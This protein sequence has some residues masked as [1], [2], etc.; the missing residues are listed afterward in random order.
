MV[1]IREL[2]KA[3]RKALFEWRQDQLLYTD[4]KAPL[5]VAYKAHCTWF[6][7]VQNDP[8]QC[9]YVGLIDTLRIG[10]VRFVKRSSRVYEVFVFLK[11]AYC[12]KGHLENL[13][14]KS[15]TVLQEQKDVQ[16][17]Y[18][19]SPVGPAIGQLLSSVGFVKDAGDSASCLYVLKL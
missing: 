19:R 6:D 7:H 12:G 13:L 1:V 5:A 4:K 15:L 11:P 14:G 10:V 16:E 8:N 2:E 17:V 3:D 18:L 9:L